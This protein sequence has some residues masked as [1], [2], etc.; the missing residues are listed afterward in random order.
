MQKQVSE[1]SFM[2]I[3]EKLLENYE[4]LEIEQQNGILNMT[5]KRNKRKIFSKHLS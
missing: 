2:K 5:V 4:V 1:E 3:G